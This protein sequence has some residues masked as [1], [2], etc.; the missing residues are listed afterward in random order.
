MTV[1]GAASA[2]SRTDAVGVTHRPA[3]P[4]PRIAC[5]VPSITE[6]LFALGLGARVVGRTGFCEHPKPAVRKVPKIGGTKDF[7]LEK[8][9]ALQ[10][11]HLI[12]N[13]DENPKERVQAAARFVPDVIVT[14]PM[15]PLDNPPL[16]RLLGGIFGVEVAAERLATKFEAAYAAAVAATKPM[17]RER[18]LYL[19]WKGPWMT[20][21]R[22]TYIARVLGSVGWEQIE[23]A[24]SERYPTVELESLLDR[25]DRILLSSEPYAFTRR[26]LRSVESIVDSVTRHPSRV[27][28]SLIDAQMTS[29]YGS[30]AIE[31]MRYLAAQRVA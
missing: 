23:V 19:I 11:T 18:V 29:W 16:Y 6:L 3:G 8:L 21:A 27:T 2:T 7:D 30:R 28:V 12:V 31:G 1:T 20:I 13:V 17:A 9:R 22:D 24:S 14:H 4:Q 26:D 15:G 25:V 10:P 5:L